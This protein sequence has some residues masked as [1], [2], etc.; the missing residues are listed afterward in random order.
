MTIN[1]P[2]LQPMTN[3][4]FDGKTF[5]STPFRLVIW[6]LRGLRSTEAARTCTKSNTLFQ[7]SPAK[8][9]HPPCH[10]HTDGVFD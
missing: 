1:M 2:R 5:G 10:C 3:G 6:T 9:I 8:L 4:A 7:T